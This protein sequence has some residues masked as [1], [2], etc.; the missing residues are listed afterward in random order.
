MF[1]RNYWESNK[2][3]L[4]VYHRF[5]INS[6]LTRMF[7]KMGGH[8]KYLHTC[9]NCIDK[10]NGL[11][12]PYV[13]KQTQS[14]NIHSMFITLCQRLG[15]AV[16]QKGG[17]SLPLHPLRRPEAKATLPLGKSAVFEDASS[18]AGDLCLNRAFSKRT[19]TQTFQHSRVFMCFS[20]SVS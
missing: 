18:P 2:H 16:T 1:V 15:L 12:Y 5:R 17:A 3:L 9:L 14:A 10:S 13:Q 20:C 11:G 6:I 7:P 8:P 4:V 19:K